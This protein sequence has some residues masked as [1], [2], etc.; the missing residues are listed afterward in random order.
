MK[1]FHDNNL[2]NKVE[3]FVEKNVRN[4]LAKH[5]MLLACFGTDAPY[6]QELVELMMC[7]MAVQMLAYMIQHV[8]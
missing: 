6:N 4:L 8:L 7:G 3:Q 1:H 2:N 5:P